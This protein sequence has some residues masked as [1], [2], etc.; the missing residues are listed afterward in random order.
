MDLPIPKTELENFRDMLSKFGNLTKVDTGGGTVTYQYRNKWGWAGYEVPPGLANEPGRPMSPLALDEILR[1]RV[2]DDFIFRDQEYFWQASLMEPVGGMDNFVKAFGRQQLT[3]RNG[4]IEGLIRFGAKVTA[5]EN[6]DDKVTIAYDDG[7]SERAL[8]ADFCISHD[9]DPDLQDAAHQ[10]AGA[11]TWSAAREAAD[12]GGRQ[13]RLAGGAVLG[14]EGSA[15]TAASPGPPIRSRRSGIRRRASCR[16]RACSPAPTCT[17]RRPSRS[18]R[19]RWRE[20]LQIAKDQ[21]EKLHPGFAAA[22]EHGIAIG[23]NNMEFERFAWADEGDP[24]FGTHAQVL[25]T[26]QGRFHMAGD[27]VTFW[28][29]WQ[30]GAILA[31]WEAVKSID[32]QANEGRAMDIS[33]ALE[34]YDRHVPFFDG[35]VKPRDGVALKVFQVGQ[36]HPARD[37]ED[38][39]GRML[40]GEFDVAEFSMSTYLMA[41]DRKLPITGVPVFPRR[42][43]S[44]GLFFVRA[45]SEL[46]TPADLRGK[47]VAI[48]SFQTTLSLLA[49]GDLK[50]EYGVPWEEIH[51]LLE[52]EEKIKFEPR[53]GL[54]HRASA[55]RHRR[56]ASAARRQGRRG[57]PAASAQVDDLGR[58]ADAAA[59]RGRGRRGAA[60]LQEVRLLPDHAHPGDQEGADRAQPGTA[61]GS[62]GDVR[63][64]AR[65]SRR[66][67]TPIRTGRAWRS[68]GAISSASR[69]CSARTSGRPG[70][71]QT[72]AI[73]SSSC[74]IRAT[75][76]SFAAISRSTS[77]LPSRR[78]IRDQRGFTSPTTSLGGPCQLW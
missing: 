68:A 50:F 27:Q 72:A 55:G 44:A 1:S 16:A 4:T 48:R 53:P 54:A 75:R 10:S 70:S 61:G 13:G 32:R 28:S 11:P 38:R 43:F 8:A 12:A 51:W 40:K 22:V 26:P 47:R 66:I 5:I 20:R 9:P 52:D 67:I 21:A 39:H 25:A 33:I 56:R 7:G 45:D 71:R 69:R 65:R 29:G 78:G 41:I 36:S 57:D 30:E 76:A 62:D 6:G 3:E 23:W 63:G 59:D 49:K 73:S 42:L 17:G 34:R 74:A 64:R 14:N 37:G 58:G 35:T 77:C 15:S 31:A 60:L 2:W 24:Q 19:C 46:R 18:M